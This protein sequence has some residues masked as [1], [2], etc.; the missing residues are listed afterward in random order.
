MFHFKTLA[1]TILFGAQLQAQ[2][3]PLTCERV[4]DH[5]SDK[6]QLLQTYLDRSSNTVANSDHLNSYD[7]TAA[8]E[9]AQE[10]KAQ[11]E[12]LEMMGLFAPRTSNMLDDSG[13]LL[14]YT[15]LNEAL[16]RDT[17]I[18]SLFQSGTTKEFNVDHPLFEKIYPYGAMKS[19]IGLHAQLSPIFAEG[20][21]R[22]LKLIS[23]EVHQHDLSLADAVKKLE[24][25]FHELARHDFEAFVDGE[26]SRL[27]KDAALTS[28]GHLPLEKDG[29]PSERALI[30]VKDARAYN[31]RFLHSIQ[32]SAMSHRYTLTKD[33]GFDFEKL[34]ETYRPRTE[35]IIH[36][37]EITK[38]NLDM[39]N[40]NIQTLNE[41]I[42]S[43]GMN[44][45]SDSGGAFFYDRFVETGLIHGNFHGQS[46]WTNSNDFAEI[47]GNTSR[48][49]A[50]QLYGRDLV[51][52]IFWPNNSQDRKIPILDKARIAVAYDTNGI[53][54]S[55]EMLI[56]S[57]TTGKWEP[58]YFERK[59]DQ[60]ALQ[61]QIRGEDVEK[62]CLRCHGVK[63]GADSLVL[64][65]RPQFLKTAEDFHAVG[66]KDQKLIE[67]FLGF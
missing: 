48:S 23:K 19:V 33:Y 37:A 13:Y 25:Q 11:R 12:Q 2:A 7:F 20:F 59:A 26:I 22:N 54:L 18:I 31:D 40:G 67:K 64:S 66:Y 9:I 39:H 41:K 56:K 34:I 32:S 47:T 15:R 45:F 46:W 27:E 29:T 61:K 52:K 36:A 24:P 44:V 1:M 4:F 51:R 35:K 53:P 60:W 6:L 42:P 57:K 17:D 58:Y 62:V 63:S 16:H 5:R 55:L 43:F 8:R 14:I 49:L 65:P 50:R 30:A 28:D 3:M 38:T 10:V 21:L